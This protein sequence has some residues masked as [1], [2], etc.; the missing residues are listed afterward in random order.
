[1]K[2]WLEKEVLL[3][4]KKKVLVEERVQKIYYQY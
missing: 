1:M 3:E 2:E 4:K